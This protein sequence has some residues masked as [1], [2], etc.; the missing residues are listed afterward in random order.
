MRSASERA[1]QKVL[2]LCPPPG[3]VG[4]I[5]RYIQTVIRA[6]QDLL[7]EENVRALTL[8][9]TPS[10]EGVMRIP[11][12]VKWRFTRS[13]LKEGGRFRPDLVVCAHLALA[14]LGW[15]FQSFYRRPYWVI[16]YGIE[17]WIR[18]PLLKRRA[19][20]RAERLIAISAFTREQVIRLHRIEA[21]RIVILPCVLDGG[22]LDVQPVWNSLGSCLNNGRRIILTVARMAAAER[23][24][25]HD[26]VLKALPA[27]IERVPDLT[28]LVV[29][30]GDDR[31]RLEALAERL[32]VK[33]HVFFTG[34]VTEAELAACYRASEVF[35]LPART[36]LDPRAPKGEGFGIVFLE[37]MGFGKPVIGPNCGA[38][39][40]VVRHEEHG[41]LVEPESPAA[42]AQALL[43]LLDSPEDARRMGHAAGLWV[44]RQFSYASFLERLQAAVQNQL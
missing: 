42:V 9:E 23:Y 25:G 20:L 24:K 32:G 27:V 12:Q 39:V 28:Y 5:K 17:A 43:R 8:P 13:V 6:L 4:G 36:V 44:R 19:L 30:D 40:Q 14:P 15:L 26:V 7:G 11:A 34:E 37:A 33:E 3:R 35:V 10:R 29:G 2:V 38:P 21:E 22:L 31:P 41:L 16:L 18:L 1:N